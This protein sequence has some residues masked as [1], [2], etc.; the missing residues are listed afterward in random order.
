M[1]FLGAAF[2]SS[3]PVSASLRGPCESRL[4]MGFL[5][6]A[7]HRLLR[8]PIDFNYRGIA[9]SCDRRRNLVLLQSEE[10]MAGAGGATPRYLRNELYS[11]SLTK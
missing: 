1:F 4:T 3:T 10:G 7:H 9:H 8:S 2:G 6:D 11:D 5:L